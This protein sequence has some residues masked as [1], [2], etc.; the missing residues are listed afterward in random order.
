MIKK[1]YWFVLGLLPLLGVILFFAPLYVGSNIYSG[2]SLP[3]FI[4]IV[5]IILGLT[6]FVIGGW[7]V[8]SKGETLERFLM[9][10]F[11]ML[12]FSMLIIAVIYTFFFYVI[13]FIIAVYQCPPNTY[14][15]PV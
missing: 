14:E 12:I 4:Y 10:I 5:S 8:W 2:Q 15:C 9:L 11:S 7:F 3:G 1:D 13:L 6:P